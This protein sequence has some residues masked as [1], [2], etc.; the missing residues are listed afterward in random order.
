MSRARQKHFQKL[1]IE[2]EGLKF[3]KNMYTNRKRREKLEF[4]RQQRREDPEYELQ[5]RELKIRVTEMGMEHDKLQMEKEEPRGQTTA[6][7]R[8][9]CI[10]TEIL[11]QRA[12]SS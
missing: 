9:H 3:E 5:N 1:K 6:N 8:M 4:E 11:K 10:L 2:E 12:N 7:E